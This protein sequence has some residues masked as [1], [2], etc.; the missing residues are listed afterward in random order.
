MHVPIITLSE[1]SLKEIVLEEPSPPTQPNDIKA[2][3]YDF[4]LSNWSSFQPLFSSELFLLQTKFHLE[5]QYWLMCSITIKHLWCDKLWIFA[6]VSGNAIH[7]PNKFGTKCRSPPSVLFPSLHTFCTSA[8]CYLFYLQ[9]YYL[10]SF[11]HFSLP[12]QD[13]S[14]CYLP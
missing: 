5:A 12:T 10:S 3:V 9:L 13:P 2:S 8:L 1:A 7:P 14:H 6:L 11:F 4:N